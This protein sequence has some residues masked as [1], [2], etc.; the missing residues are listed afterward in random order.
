[1]TDMSARAHSSDLPEAHVSNFSALKSRE[2]ELLSAC[3]WLI[4]QPYSTCIWPLFGWYCLQHQ[5]GE[6]LAWRCGVHIDS[7]CASRRSYTEKL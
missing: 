6:I 5:L 3:A 4:T 2:W 1:M 7:G